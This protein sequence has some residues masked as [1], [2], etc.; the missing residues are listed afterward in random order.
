M[1]DNPAVPS[2]TETVAFVIDGQVQ[3]V[4]TTQ[5]RFAALLTRNP[6]IVAVEPAL[7]GEISIGWTYS[8][9]SGFQAPVNDTIG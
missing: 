3:E 8:K 5:E 2:M 6:V 4:M 9:D 1:S 7:V